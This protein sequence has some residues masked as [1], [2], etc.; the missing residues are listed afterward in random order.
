[1]HASM[2][3]MWA[4]VGPFARAIVALLALMSIASLA[5]AIDRLLALARAARA[6]EDHVRDWRAVLAQDLPPDTRREVYERTVR[7]SLLATGSALRRGHGILANVGS[8]APFVGLVGTVIGI[9]DA[10][11]HIAA[12]GQGGVGEVSAGIAEAL[13]TTAFGIGVAIPA[14]WLLNYLTQRT[15]RLLVDME[16]RAEEVAIETLGETRSEARRTRLTAH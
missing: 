14:V 3:E 16:V 6:I 8:T 5:T 12:A 7:R 4:A 11:Q 9:V 2:L 13:V 1:M 15:K 10:F